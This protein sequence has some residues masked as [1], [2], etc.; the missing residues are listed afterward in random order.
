MSFLALL[1]PVFVILGIGGLVVG[2]RRALPAS[3]RAGGAS[4]PRRI[5]ALVSGSTLQRNAERPAPKD[6]P[7]CQF[8]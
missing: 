5:R 1:A 8:S 7:F 4:A 6:R 3:A 2:A